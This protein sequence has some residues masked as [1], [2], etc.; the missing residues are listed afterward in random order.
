MSDVLGAWWL[1][2]GFGAWCL[3]GR[4]KELFEFVELA[5]GTGS[6]IDAGLVGFEIGMT[7]H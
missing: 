2:L 4:L 1:V 6:G 7:P 5:S 3:G